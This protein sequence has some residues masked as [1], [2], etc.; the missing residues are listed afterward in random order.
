MYV[1]GELSPCKYLHV[2]VRMYVL[3][4]CMQFEMRPA[5]YVHIHML[6]CIYTYTCYHVY[7][8]TH[9]TTQYV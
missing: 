8:H 7:T 3:N 6:P 1:C 5:L 4:A 2:C 9:A